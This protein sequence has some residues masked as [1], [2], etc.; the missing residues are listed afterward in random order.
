MSL[1]LFS[2]IV[3][4]GAIQA[5]LLGITL[6]FSRAHSRLQQYALAFFMLILAY[7]GFETLNWST[8]TNSIAF[9]FFTFVPI[10]GLGPCVYLYIYS[11]IYPQKP[12]RIK[13]YF[14]PVWIMLALR[15]LLWTDVWLFLH[16]HGLRMHPMALDTWYGAFAE[17]LSVVYFWIFMVRTLLL[18]RRFTPANTHLP[19]TEFTMA[20]RWLTAF[21]W[22]MAVLGVM[23]LGTIVMPRFWPAVYYWQYYP[24][25]IYLAF[26]IYW[27]AFAGYQQIK[28][29]YIVQ[30]KAAATTFIDSIPEA[31]IQRCMTALE[32][33]M[34]QDKLYLD[35]DLT[36]QSLAQKI[37][38]NP[39]I[40]SAV[41]NQRMQ[42]GFNE[43]VN[44]CRTGEAQ[45]RLLDPANKH[46]SISG[47]AF[48]CGFNSQATFQRAFKLH[49]G[50]TPK[51]FVQNHL[52]KQEN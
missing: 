11:F 12:A 34:E 14:L 40:I 22:N 4:L 25:E 18:F 36:L 16:G 6:L 41:L 1:S 28:I 29:V 37:Q 7:N 47:I 42:K 2:L 50:C 5:L 23:W 52:Q 27:I 13:W 44:S 9:Q 51:E 15:V 32:Y 39:K 38:F 17:P 48:D 24:I 21:V 45:K 3:L 30:Q 49:T 46:L 31:D 35:P 33:A 43:F 26:F 19:A 10:F 20:R 8:N